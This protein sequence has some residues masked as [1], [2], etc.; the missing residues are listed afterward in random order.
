LKGRPGTRF[1]LLMAI[2]FGSAGEYV[3][4]SI[5]AQPESSDVNLILTSP[6]RTGLDMAFWSVITCLTLGLFVS[7]WPQLVRPTSLCFLAK[8]VQSGLAV[9]ASAVGI[10]LVAFSLF[11]NRGGCDGDRILGP[12]FVSTIQ[13]PSMAVNGIV[14]LS[15]LFLYLYLGRRAWRIDRE[16]R[17]MAARSLPSSAIPWL[18][19][20]IGRLAWCLAV[21]SSVGLIAWQAA[22]LAR[23]LL[24]VGGVL[25]GEIVEARGAALA[26]RMN[27]AAWRSWSSSSTSRA[28]SAATTRR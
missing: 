24:G 8:A 6:A 26:E 17:A 9:L 25:A 27:V 16:F 20:L 5:G 19:R 12:T 28:S 10:A 15:F 13:L 18:R 4:S 23:T 1:Q 21:A 3:R 7:R 2:L 22:S 14:S 11:R